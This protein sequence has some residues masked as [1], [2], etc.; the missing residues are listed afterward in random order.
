VSRLED[1]EYD[2]ESGLDWLRSEA[3]RGLIIP[4]EQA[5]GL[6]IFKEDSFV[7]LSGFIN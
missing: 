4:T 5:A 7:S 2:L 6:H 1:K 3:D